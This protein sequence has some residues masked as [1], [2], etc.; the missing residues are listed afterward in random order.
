[1]HTERASEVV[2]EQDP[3]LESTSDTLV[4]LPLPAPAAATA[5]AVLPD[6]DVRA[7]RPPALRFLLRLDTARRLA[8]IITLLALDLLGVFAA[9]FTALGIK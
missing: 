4:D 5:Y 9:V 6:R 3:H 1:M 8:R 7:K 2:R